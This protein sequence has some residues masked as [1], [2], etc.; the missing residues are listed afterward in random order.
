MVVILFDKNISHSLLRNPL[1]MQIL[2]YQSFFHQVPDHRY[3]LQGRSGQEWQSP[4]AFRAV[5]WNRLDVTVIY[6]D[7]CF[8]TVLLEP[9][10]AA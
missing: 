6:R 9:P 2:S 8:Y 10:D 4:I 3:F 5:Q 1:W 7:F